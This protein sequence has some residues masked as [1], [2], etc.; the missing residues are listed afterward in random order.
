M[1]KLTTYATLIGVIG[2]IGG[3]F[4]TW[5]EFNTRLDA[6]ESKKIVSLAPINKQVLEMRDSISALEVDLIDRIDALR[7]KVEAGNEVDLSALTDQIEELASD[8]KAD[9]DAMKET[10]TKV[11]KEVS[12]ALKENE[13]Q[14]QKIEAVRLKASNPLA[15]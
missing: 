1:N 12:I 7:E 2:A 8:I 6:I 13:L 3:G 5:G 9:M 15:S 4:Y 14:D 10:L 11:D